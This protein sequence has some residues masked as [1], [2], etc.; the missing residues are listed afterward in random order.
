MGNL[1]II[2]HFLLFGGNPKKINTGNVLIDNDSSL[3][4]LA[5]VIF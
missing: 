4:E 2:R 5:L 3:P 1:E